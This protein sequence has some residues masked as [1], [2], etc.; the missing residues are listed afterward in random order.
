M[1]T[2]AQVRT[3]VDTKLASLWGN[4]QTRQANYFAT[5]GRYWQGIITT[6][7]DKLPDN[8]ASGNVLEMTPDLTRRPS[9]QA[10]S[11][12]DVGLVSG[13][14]PMAIQIDVYQAPSGYGYIATVYVQYRGTIYFR[15][16][17]VGPVDGSASWAI[18]NPNPVG[19]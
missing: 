2:L 14:L 6:D 5:H 3:A 11:W 16:A 15:S 9:D 13:N 7:V 12:V 10:T 8:L 1:P 4:V 18:Y 19:P 17:S